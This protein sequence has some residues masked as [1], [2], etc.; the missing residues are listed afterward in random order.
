MAAAFAMV[1][2]Q[3]D[4]NE[5]GVVA[6][7]VATV[8]FEVGAPQ[9][10]AYSLGQLATNLKYAVYDADGNILPELTVTDAEI[11]GKTN[12]KIELAN[13]KSYSIIFWAEADNAPYTVDFENKTVTVNYNGAVCND[14]SRDAFYA[15]K[16]FEVKGAAKLGV[17]LR[18]PFAQVNVGTSDLAAAQN[19]GFDPKSSSL[20]VKN[21]FSTLNLVDGTATD[22]VAEVEFATENIPA[23]DETFPVANH[24]YMAM[25]YVLVGKDQASYDVK[26]TIT[27]EDNTVITNTIGA[28]PMQ[29]N[30][31]TNIYGK[32]L[33]STTDI[34]VE[35]KPGYNEPANEL[36]A[37]QKAALNGGTVTLTEN[38]V[39]TTPLNVLAEMTIDLNGKTITGPSVAKDADGNRIHSII[40][41]GKLSIINGTISSVA[42]N[43]GSAIYTKGALTLDNVTIN[44]APSDTATGDYASY[45]VNAEGTAAKL[46]VNNSTIKGRGAVGATK[47]AKV[48]INGGLY[49]TPAPVWGHAVY[50]VG[51]GTQVVIN[52]GTFSEGYDYAANN[53]GMYQIYSGNKAQ[54]IVNGGTF[55]NWDC[56]NGYDLCTATEGTITIYGGNFA[57][58]PASQ[59]GKNY[60]ADGYKTIVKDGKYYVVADEVGAVVANDAELKAAFD[61]GHTTISMKAGIYDTKNFQ[62]MHKTLYLKGIEEGVK[63]YNSQNND[64]ACTSLDM[65]TVTFENLTIETLGGNYKGFARMNGTYNNCTIVNNYFTCYGEHIFNNCTFNAPTLTGS[66]KNEHCVWTYG[67][68]EVVF[69]NCVFNYSD[70]CVNV[71]V[72]N[73]GNT[74]G[75][76]SAVTFTQCKFNTENT[77]S[78]G[79]V[80]VNSTPFTAGVTVVLDGCTAPAYGEMVYVS[81]WDNKKGKNATILVD[82]E[83]L[84]TPVTTAEALKEAINAGEQTIYVSGQIDLTE[85][86][87]ANY[88]GTIIGADDTACINTRTFVVNYADEAYHLSGKTINFK[89]ITIKVPAEDG[90]FLKTGFVAAGTMNFDHCVF[91]GQ[92]TLNGSATWTFDDCEFGGADS[93][94]YASFV[95]GAKK[96]TF[97][98]CSFSGVDRAAKV[99]GS[100]GAIDVE[101]NNCTFTSTT[102]NKYAVNIDA[103]YATTKVALNGCSQTGMPGLYL[104]TGANATVYVDGVQK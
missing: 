75:I 65:C 59:N 83:L 74:P 25:S 56:A 20:K 4:I 30:Y 80:E 9:M 10:R 33:T 27:A 21:V 60:V 52:G 97:N 40:N 2:C 76:T 72:D 78:E 89:N 22:N 99:Y 16:E 17:D 41:N 24:A 81:P 47:G 23:A 88:N 96:A 90:D 32:L 79:A 67:A 36:S 51:E 101:Y 18:R 68:A 45:A 54:V 98:R 91:E 63:I 35:I 50:A 71:Y 102:P 86:I 39:L 87:L 66:F 38:V 92:V 43:G 29:A 5:V 12:V 95:Y 19:S 85:E 34:N 13:N 7:G 1:A 49:H 42:V 62:V 6:D 55:E 94:A 77:A 82:G 14:E 28:V 104:V 61:A 58:N 37:L 70:R 93:G 3:T 48:E 26:Y 84:V 46:I 73:G 31:R 69:N 100:G 64:V 44:G 53:W 8:E 15:Y 11:N 57:D 103:S